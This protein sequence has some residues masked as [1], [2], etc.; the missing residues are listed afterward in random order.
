MRDLREYWTSYSAKQN[1]NLNLPDVNE[2]IYQFFTPVN[3][4]LCEH[5]ANKELC[6]LWMAQ[7]PT[8]RLHEDEKTL[9]N[10]SWF[11]AWEHDENHRPHESWA[12]SMK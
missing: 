3:E 4:K 10:T 7:D 2:Y 1:K 8:G 11:V 5:H 12:F 9:P 6:Y